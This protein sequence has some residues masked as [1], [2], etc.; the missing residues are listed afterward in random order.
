MDAL[1]TETKKWVPYEG[2]EGGDGWRNTDTDEV[3][4]DDEP[5]GPVADSDSAQAE[6]EG[7][8]L[9][10]A[11]ADVLGDDPGR[12]EFAD[13]ESVVE[14]NTGIDDVDFSSFDADQTEVAAAELGRMNARGDVEALESFRSSVPE[15]AREDYGDLP[16]HYDRDSRGISVD[17]RAL[18]QDVTTQLNEAGITSTGEVEHLLQHLA[19]THAHAEALENGDAEAEGDP[20]ESAQQQLEDVDDVDPAGIAKTTGALALA[21]GAT[22]VAETMT[23]VRNDGPT[24]DQLRRA[25]RFFGGPELDDLAGGDGE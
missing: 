18:N 20:S 11:V 22:L 15:S 5:P 4:Y 10:R 13:A 6:A 2:P 7:R 24:S 9:R 8:E 12:E 14:S 23:L 1:A 21:T 19:A 3:I 16:M 17:P 25:Y